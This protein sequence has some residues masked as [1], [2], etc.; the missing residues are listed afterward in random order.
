MGKKSK[1]SKKGSKKRPRALGTPQ[2]A[3]VSTAESSVVDSTNVSV[4]QGID[5][6]E[7]VDKHVPVVQEATQSTVEPSTALESAQEVSEPVVTAATVETATP[8]VV[9]GF[10]TSNATL[11]APEPPTEPATPA[12]LE[13]EAVL[14]LP[15]ESAEEPSTEPPVQADLTVEEIRIPVPTEPIEPAVIE[16]A[17]ELQ[18][19]I[20]EPIE[21]VPTETVQNEA[22]QP[23]TEVAE[24]IIEKQETTVEPVVERVTETVEAEISWG[25]T[26]A[27]ESMPWDAPAAEDE[28]MPWEEPAK[29]E[30][31]EPEEPAPVTAAP[32]ETAPIPE[33]HVETAP[34]PIPE[35]HAET[36]VATETVV[37]TEIAA[38]AEPVAE[39]E[40]M[41]WDDD[42]EDDSFLK[43]L[44]A[45]QKTTV[46][47]AAPVEQLP[48]ANRDARPSSIDEKLDFLQKD[49][50]LL[51]DDI[52]DDDLLEDDAPAPVQ[53]VI[54]QSPQKYVP[55]TG[56]T[57]PQIP[58]SQPA[59]NRA[60]DYTRRQSSPVGSI[61]SIPQQ[62]ASQESTQHKSMIKT[63]ETQKH[64]S[65]AYDFPDDVLS[66]YQ[67]P[68]LRAKSPK[69]SIYA[70][71]ESRQ[72]FAQQAQPVHSVQPAQ[73][74]AVP[75]PPV[76]AAVPPKR[77][78]PYA[79]KSPA[80]RPASL[81]APSMA[82]GSTAPPSAIN[83]PQVPNLSSAAPQSNV[84]DHKPPPPVAN[85][86]P[87]PNFF[88][89]LPITTHQSATP[90]VPNPYGNVERTPSVTSESS[91]PLSPYA[92]RY[93]ATAGKPL[94]PS[95]SRKTTNPYAPPGAGGHV[96]TP[97]TSSN[98]GTVNPRVV[99]I[100]QKTIGNV[101]SPRRDSV[102]SGSRYGPPDQGFP[103]QNFAQ[104]PQSPYNN[105]AQFQQPRPGYQPQ[106]NQPFSPSNAY[107]PG[108]QGQAQQFQGQPQQFQGQKQFQGQQQFQGQPP[109]FQGQQ[110]PGQPQQQF[111]HHPNTSLDAVY[112]ATQTQA[113]SSHNRTRSKS[114]K[115]L[116]PMSPHGQR[117]VPGIVHGPAPVVINPENLVRRQWPLFSFSASDKVATMSPNTDGY[118][119]R[120]ANIKIRSLSELVHEDPL[121]SKFPG[122]LVKGK[123]KRK[124]LEK[125]IADKLN[126]VGATDIAA[127][128]NNPL[129]IIWT[130]LSVLITEVNT[131]EDLASHAYL[132]KVVNA[133]DPGTKVSGANKPLDIL[134]LSRAAD[135]GAASVKTFN[136]H[137]VD[138]QGVSKVYT[139]LEA[140]QTEPALEYAVS[141]GDWALAFV[142]AGMMGPTTVSEVVKLFSKDR[143]SG[144]DTFDQMMSFF[145]NASV[146]GFQFNSNTSW[147]VEN[148]TAV[149]AFILLSTSQPTQI[150]AQM[151]ASLYSTG[152][153]DYAFI[154]YLLS[155]QP[156]APAS[157]PLDLDSVIA[158]EIYEY[159]LLEAQTHSAS[160]LPWTLP[161]KID[162][163]GY[164][165]DEGSSAGAKKYSDSIQSI[166]TSKQFN[167]GPAEIIGAQRLAARVER[168]SSGAQ[169]WF[170]SKLKVW[171][172][173]DKSFNKFV[174]GEELPPEARPVSEVF[175]NFT[176]PVPSRSGSRMDLNGLSTHTSPQQ[177]LYSTVPDVNPANMNMTVASAV[178]PALRG[179]T[180]RL[181]GLSP[182]APPSQVRQQKSSPSLSH[183]TLQRLPSGNAP[184]KP[185]LPHAQSRSSV[186]LYQPVNPEG[187]PSRTASP[188][189]SAPPRASLSASTSPKLS[190]AVPHRTASPVL[191]KARKP[192]PPAQS[193]HQEPPQS[194]EPPRVLAS[195]VL[196]PVSALPHAPVA[197]VPTAP[198]AHS[199]PPPVHSPPPAAQTPPPPA[200]L[201]PPPPPAAQAPPKASHMPP[202]VSSPLSAIP[203][204]TELPKAV[205]PSAAVE[206]AEDPLT[207]HIQH[208]S[209]EHVEHVSDEPVAPIEH[210]AP[211]AV[212]PV[213]V[214]QPDQTIPAP[215]PVHSAPVHPI[216][217]HPSL[218]EQHVAGAHEKADADDSNAD[219]SNPDILQSIVAESTHNEI[220]VRSQSP[221]IPPAIAEATEPSPAP[222]PV[223]APTPKRNVTAPNPYAPRTKSTRKPTNPYANI[224]AH[225]EPSATQKSP[226][227]YA[228]QTSQAEEPVGE[229]PV[230][231]DMGVPEDMADFDMYSFGG[232]H[233]PPPGSH[234][235]KEE[236]EIP[237]EE[238]PKEEV[239][240]TT[241][242]D[243][244]NTVS[245]RPRSMFG[246]A[247][248]Q[249]FGGARPKTMYDRPQST[250]EDDD[251]DVSN[252]GARLRNMFTPA[253]SMSMMSSNTT[254]N[255]DI[256][257]S[258]IYTI[259]EEKR[260]YA[261]EADEEEYMDDIIDEDDEDDHTLKDVEHKKEEEERKRNEEA[262][263]KKKEQQRQ[264]QQR[265]HEEAEKKSKTLHKKKSGWFGWMHK[266][267]DAPKAIK[268]KLGEENHFYFDEKL[269]RWINKD[270]PV[271][272]QVSSTPPPPPAKKATTSSGPSN[273]P[274]APLPALP[275]GGPPQRAPKKKSDGIDDLLSMAQPP[276]RARRSA[277]KRGPRRGYVDVMAQ[278]H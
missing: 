214:L 204:A 92:N 104:P 205:E 134:A 105:Q 184:V 230:L 27:E 34:T 61:G 179:S 1:K 173:L 175:S 20:P 190:M 189:Y 80:A 152:H 145:V 223:E 40:K 111:K 13:A 94:S 266:D 57:I 160:T 35:A 62:L 96:S 243:F 78:N 219:S 234:A 172:H 55:Q 84:S 238:E 270:A 29:E 164:L 5:S 148:F 147:L 255:S 177:P 251:E 113:A 170:G 224:Y 237:E 52:M 225:R 165:A 74:P 138:R 26:D 14:E 273:A 236:P 209:D 167:Y 10:N 77:A 221:S 176:S 269:N 2:S 31:E 217:V 81:Y 114:N 262:E 90:H 99:P 107:T 235:V 169:S 258:A 59:F 71:I 254:V 41:P 75:Q 67:S 133:L 202:R 97:S 116:P 151:S 206:T 25:P 150:M 277:S 242:D 56:P 253:R 7:V 106:G 211:V 163:A 44:A 194:T 166:I 158:L 132:Q 256:R 9:E 76:P 135:N 83:A 143:F 207:E 91:R 246:G 264:Q 43:D 245:Y 58:P 156:T 182:Y 272:D 122:P 131:A 101:L 195:S 38:P 212:E 141:E 48:F 196:P 46:S 136:A 17:P 18:T 16:T 232:Y 210:A 60:P 109:Q 21:T 171:D 120:I 192:V 250:Y 263:R 208:A 229:P 49:D 6:P 42:A 22:V 226:A 39:T 45:S 140:G 142:I 137:Q 127:V 198:A 129:Q 130:V 249:S 274:T 162:H 30:P 154:A 54:S 125:W 73:P 12:P 19:E 278:Q 126:A 3:D 149:L 66:K 181:R 23:A 32:V 98:P 121:T 188:V 68:T 79:P 233:V 220:D 155:G 85:K 201:T 86:A 227:K 82:S 260:L 93:G 119:R 276:A 87:A 146:G 191:P 240:N 216:P 157:L 271:E 112:G 89:E 51:L 218:P 24:P 183:P 197:H 203:T 161:I 47:A 241:E 153:Q 64:K 53:P 267:E 28:R 259:T 168:A 144:N 178:G 88:A 128:G 199:P 268:A 174:V 185:P 275:N 248:S 36:A 70:R 265:Q 123:S 180:Q 8:E 228:P 118:G 15:S 244:N 11:P 33:T 231:D 108:F 159:V 4:D 69:Q 257:R 139:W 186:N 103:Q 239:S 110:H 65:D 187:I 124:D 200:T 50:D 252:P 222:A 213:D 95:S 63:M 115:M 215:A 72:T 102:G 37:P 247:R 193:F 117:K 261:N 100:P